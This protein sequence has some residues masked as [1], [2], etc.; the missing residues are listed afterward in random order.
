MTTF[1]NAE[2]FAYS[3]EDPAEITRLRYSRGNFTEPPS[4]PETAFADAGGDD[5]FHPD[6][7]PVGDV[8]AKLEEAKAAGDI[9]EVARIVAEEKA[10]QARK[11]ILGA[12]AS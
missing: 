7:H 4:S 6:A 9:A 8:L 2:G 3:T 12:P 1:Y 5:R 11:G 10:G